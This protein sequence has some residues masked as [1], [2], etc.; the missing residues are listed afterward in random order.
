[1]RANLKS[2]SHGFHLFEVPF[3]WELTQETIDLPLGCLQGGMAPDIIPGALISESE[4]EG[5]GSRGHTP[6][7][8][9]TRTRAST[10]P[11]YLDPSAATL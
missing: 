2:I 8:L 6:C 1:M 10:I 9:G 5:A 3:V 7:S 11:V 4:R